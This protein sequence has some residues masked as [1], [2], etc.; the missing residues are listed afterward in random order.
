MMARLRLSTLLVGTNL[1][2]VLVAVVIVG[3]AAGSRLE[4]LADEQALAHVALAG[5]SAARALEAEGEDLAVST[6]LLA[7]RP[8][9]ARLLREGDAAP[10]AQYLEIFRRTGQLSGCAVLRGGAPVAAAG[11][12]LAWAELR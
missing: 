4:R 11:A 3:L 2:L 6:R 10:L 7:E 5:S 9:L 8:T 12:P 1:V